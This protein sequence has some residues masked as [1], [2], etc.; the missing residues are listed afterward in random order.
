[1]E[2]SYDTRPALPQALRAPRAGR[3]VS[4]L[5]WINRRGTK[6][7][8][9]ARAQVELPGVGSACSQQAKAEILKGAGRCSPCPKETRVQTLM[10]VTFAE[11]LWVQDQAR[12]LIHL[13]LQ[14]PRSVGTIISHHSTHEESQ[15]QRTDGRSQRWLHRRLVRCYLSA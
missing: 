5:S 7:V 10:V 14:Q 6:Y 4:R 3:A 15:P 9:K 2:Q 13:R 11:L 12:V 1:M 8:M